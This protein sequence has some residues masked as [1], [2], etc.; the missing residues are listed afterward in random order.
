MQ[1]HTSNYLKSTN[2]LPHEIDCEKCF[3]QDIMDIHHIEHRQKNNPDLD[4]A[5]NL[6]A[7]CRKCHKWIHENN[8][9]EN[10]QMLRDLIANR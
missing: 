4:K 10:K 3:S 2:K 5:E 1:R 6:I 7:L 8:T 9:V